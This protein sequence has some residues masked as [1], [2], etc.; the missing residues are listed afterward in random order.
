MICNEVLLQKAKRILKVYYTEN[1]RPMLKRKNPKPFF[2]IQFENSFWDMVKLHIYVRT[3]EISQESQLSTYDLLLSQ[4]PKWSTSH[5]GLTSTMMIKQHVV[6][7][8]I[9][10]L[11]MNVIKASIWKWQSQENISAK[12]C[13]LHH[14]LRIVDGQHNSKTIECRECFSLADLGFRY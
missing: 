3:Q 2:S 14:G 11:Y 6:Q 10:H 8:F 9:Y 5:K 4:F 7:R 13:F 1:K 12:S